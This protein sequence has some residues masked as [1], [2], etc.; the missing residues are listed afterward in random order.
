MKFISIA[1]LT[2][3]MIFQSGFAQKPQ[4]DKKETRKAVKTYVQDNVLPVLQKQRAK[5]DLELS[6]SEQQALGQLREELKAL[7]A[8]GKDHKTER[9][10]QGEMP[11]QE[12]R[13]AM[14]T[15]AKTHRLIM[16]RAWAIADAH[17]TSIFGLIDEMAPNMETW[18]SDLQ[19]ITGDR[20]EKVR[21]MESDDSEEAR[22]P[23]K[24]GH[25][26]GKRGHGKMGRLKKLGQPV[27]F[28]LWD[29]KELP[30]KAGREGGKGKEERGSQVS[31]AKVV[32]NPANGSHELR[33]NL[34]N[35]GKVTV[36]LMDYS[37]KPLKTMFSGNASAGQNTIS[38]STGELQEGLYFY[39]IESPDGD[40]AVRFFVK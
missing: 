27:F 38:L 9:R 30:G 24:K 21:K 36:T 22:S 15:Q 5:L 11:T 1:M 17:E 39:Q 2:L 37:G 33:Y 4:E 18:R 28:L 32:P 25:H 20:K 8:N 19:N 34:E 35:A 13:D 14:R 7:H 6:A 12:E 3:A 40:Q 23:R 26:H 31:R 29:G 16:N 10:E